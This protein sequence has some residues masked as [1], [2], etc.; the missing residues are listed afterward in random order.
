[1][2]NLEMRRFHWANLGFW[3]KNFSLAIDGDP[4]EFGRGL[5]VGFG[6]FTPGSTGAIAAKG[7]VRFVLQCRGVDV[8]H[9]SAH[10]L[11]TTRQ[12]ALDVAFAAYPSRF[13]GR[14]PAPAKLPTAAWINPPPKKETETEIPTETLHLAQ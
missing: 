13:K 4:F 5:D 12:A 2:W 11:I 10:A 1:M 9:G 3:G 7:H 8:A 14:R 6:A